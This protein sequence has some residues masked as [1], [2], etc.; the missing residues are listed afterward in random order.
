MTKQKTNAILKTQTKKDGTS[1]KRKKILLRNLRKGGAVQWDSKV[2]KDRRDTAEK[3][4]NWREVQ[5]DGIG[6]STKKDHE[7]CTVYKSRKYIED[8]KCMKRGIVQWHR[9]AGRQTR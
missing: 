3:Q 6:R 9:E 5:S 7:E 2:I 4:D 1:K 8:R